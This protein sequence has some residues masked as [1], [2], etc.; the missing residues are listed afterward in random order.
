MLN[1][2]VHVK[3][4]ECTKGRGKRRAKEANMVDAVNATC[5]SPGNYSYITQY[6]LTLTQP[7]CLY[8]YEYYRK[9][10]LSPGDDGTPSRATSPD[11]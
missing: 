7:R 8:L 1:A 9:Y 10:A 11:S 3:E 2:L 6:G 4:S 5:S